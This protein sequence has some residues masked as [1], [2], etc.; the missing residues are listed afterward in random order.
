VK[1]LVAKGLAT[2]VSAGRWEPTPQGKATDV[3]NAAPDSYEVVS[4]F[5]RQ[6]YETKFAAKHNG[7]AGIFQVAEHANFGRG[8]MVR[9][10][11]TN[12][13]VSNADLLDIAPYN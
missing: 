3:S 5:A 9:N 8:W 11:E 13:I 2:E 7:V 4:G 1:L 6:G 12:E 10:I